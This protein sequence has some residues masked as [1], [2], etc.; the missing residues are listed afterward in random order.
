MHNLHGQQLFMIV[1]FEALARV[2][3]LYIYILFCTRVY[4]YVHVMLFLMNAVI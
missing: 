2:M 4:L 3:K 1:H